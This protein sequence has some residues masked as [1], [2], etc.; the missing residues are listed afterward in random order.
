MISF[1]NERKSDFSWNT[2]ALRCATLFSRRVLFRVQQRE[3]EIHLVVCLFERAS[4]FSPRSLCSFTTSEKDR[5]QQ[6]LF[7]PSKLAARR[8]ISRSSSSTSRTL[9]PIISSHATCVTQYHFINN[10][11]SI[12]LWVE[13]LSYTRTLALE[14]LS[15][16]SSTLARRCK[17]VVIRWP[18]TPAIM[19]RSDVSK[20]LETAPSQRY[21]LANGFPV[22]SSE[23]S[24]PWWLTSKSF[25]SPS[26]SCYS[27]KQMMLYYVIKSQPA[28]HSSSSV[29]FWRRALK[30]YFTATSRINC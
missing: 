11:W 20:R 29:S 2:F 7:P 22:L 8:Q 23:S 15:D 21:L 4:E 12:L 14:A 24:M 9:S 13:L 17:S 19:I 25:I 30:L 6:D 10:H 18:S 28:F 27:K 26:I 1:L 3:F 5:A 16:S